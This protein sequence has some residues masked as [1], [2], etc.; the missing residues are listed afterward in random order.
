MPRSRT[1]LVAALALGAAVPASAGAWGSPDVASPEGRE[2]RQPAVAMNGAGTAVMAW[3][4]GPWT[5]RSIAV[6]VGRDGAWGVARRVSPPGGVAFDPRVA[7]GADGSLMV[8]WRQAIGDQRLR[9]G[10]RIITRTRFVARARHRDPSGDWGPVA[11]LSPPRLKVGA[12][13]LAMGADGTAV[14]T[15]H[16][17][18]GTSPRLS[19]YVSQVQASVWRGGEWSPMRRVSGTAGCREERRP[20]A[21]VGARGQAVVWWQCDVRGGS[22]SYGVARGPEDR[23]WSA[24][25]EL[26]FRTRGDQRSDL[27]VAA[28]GSI[29]AVSAALGGPVRWWRG[30]AGD[31]GI[32]LS[33]LPRPGLPERADDDAG[34]PRID[35]DSDGDALT[36]WVAATDPF[37]T[38]AAPVAASLGP[39]TPVSL[40]GQGPAG[41]VQVDSSLGR[42]GAVAWREMVGR[43][44]AAVVAAVRGGD[45]SWSPARRISTIGDIN[46]N[47]GPRLAA[48]GNRAIAVWEREIGGR[49]VIE[50]AVF[51][52]P[53]AAAQRRR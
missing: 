43:Q 33:E 29:S 28:D 7:V 22:T 11:T 25:R 1:S 44:Q 53:T 40:P 13:E 21:A 38:R 42:R 14:A 51:P 48:A 12:P 9:V 30:T 49:P 24:R 39:G 16:W 41:S 32:Q 3:V 35:I 36:A 31:A 26:P 5:G 8:L 27:G 34:G 20:R 6:S 46:A 47:A 17:G 19:G 50:R 15:W 18:T 23:R 37:T 4:D 2:G 45:G 10:G 52:D